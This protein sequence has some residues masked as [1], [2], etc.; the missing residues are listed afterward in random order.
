MF[1]IKKSFTALTLAVAFTNTALAEAPKNNLELH[2]DYL[3]QSALVDAKQDMTLG[4]T[5][6]V[7][8]ASNNFEPMASDS[9]TLVA[10]ITITTLKPSVASEDNDA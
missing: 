2:T 3:V 4:V 6:D 1:T 7:L 10:E 8:T 9:D 5:Y